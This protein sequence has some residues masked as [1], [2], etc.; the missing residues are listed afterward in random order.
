MEHYKIAEELFLQGYNC[1]QSV[2]AAFSD[3]TKMDLNTS[4][5]VSVALGAGVARS[6][7]VCGAVLGMMLVLGMINDPKDKAK[8]YKD[9]QLLIEKFK[10]VNKTIICK[11]L[12]GIFDTSPTPSVRDENYYKKRPCKDMVIDACMILD[13]FLNNQK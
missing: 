1:S 10:Q 7:E 11:E 6:R 13:E 2:F 4:L 5:K 9:G 3:I 8:V 12:L